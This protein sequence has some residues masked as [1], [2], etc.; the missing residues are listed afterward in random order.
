L[1]VIVEEMSRKEIQD[2]LGLKHEGNFRD[3][4]LDPA[5][6]EGYIRMKYPDKP[7]HPKQKYLI[8]EKG[9]LFLK[10]IKNEG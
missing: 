8:T 4:H 2:A 3:N 5:L 1:K 9:S 6:S 7:N 10:M